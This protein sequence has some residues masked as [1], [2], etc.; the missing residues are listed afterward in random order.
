MNVV[1]LIGALAAI[2]STT[3]FAPQAIKIIKSRRTADLSVGMYALTVTGFALW[4]TYGLLNGDWVLIVP[5]V[6]CLTLSAFILVMSVLPR[7]ERETIA[8]T[9][10]PASSSA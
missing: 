1:S 5:N 6:I 10:D 7:R 2:A 9:L 8:K 3:S 4:L